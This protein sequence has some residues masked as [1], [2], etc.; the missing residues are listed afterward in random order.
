MEL[1]EGEIKRALASGDLPGWRLGQRQIFKNFK[2][3]TFLD[4]IAFINRVAER[5]EAAN[6]HP[7]LEN[8]FN[9]VRIGLQTW[10][11]DAVTEKDLAL[12]RAIEAAVTPSEEGGGRDG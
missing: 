2:F 6:H 10:S 3:P 4:A 8:H 7:D 9:R 5:A 11:E 1:S 12:A